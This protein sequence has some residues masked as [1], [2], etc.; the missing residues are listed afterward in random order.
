M[1]RTCRIS[2]LV[3]SLILV[4][5]QGAAKVAGAASPLAGKLIYLQGK[6]EVRRGQTEIWQA[7]QIDQDLLAGDAVKT[8]PLSR[9]AILCEDESQIKLN[10]HTL[11]VIESTAPSPRLQPAAMPATAPGAAPSLYGVPQGE[12]WLRNKNEKF[13]FELKT[14]SVSAAIRGTEF[15]LRVAADGT[16]SLTLLEGSLRL[17]NEYGALVLEPGEEGLARPGQAPTKR[18]L[19]QP[20]DAVQW[21]LFYPG[22][23]SYRDLPLASLEEGQAP[24]GSPV[25]AAL[26]RDSEAAYDRGELAQA[27]E[28]AEAA[29]KQDPENRR[30][31]T[32]LGW[33][34]LQRHAPEEAL[35][36]FRRVAAPEAAAGIGAALARYRLGDVTGAY[37]LLLGAHQKL[38]P[39]PLSRTMEGYFALL[40]GKVAEARALLET[41]S[42]QAPALVLPRALLAQIYLVQNRKDAARNEAAQAL[43][44]APGSPLAQLTMGLV[45]IAYFE[46]PSAR[47]HLEKALAADPGFIDAYVYLAKLWLGGDYLD[48]AWKTIEAALKLAPREGEVLA[49]AGFIRL[50]Y[51]DYRAAQEFFHQAIKASP[52]LGEPHLGLAIYQFRYRNYIRGVA[53]MLT[54]T[55][56]E[57]RVSQ[58]QSE[59]GKALYQVRA[60][61]KSLEVYDYAKTLDPKD[62][63][64]YL[65][66]G[67]ALTDLNRPGEAIQEIN[68]SIELN[69][70]RAVFRSR[71]GLDRDLAVRNSDLAR[72]YNQLAL[73]EW[74]QSKA[75]TAVKNDPTNSSAHLFLMHSYLNLAQS[76]NVGAAA[77]EELLYRLLAPANQAT[78]TESDDYTPMFEMPYVRAQVAGSIGAWDGGGSFQHPTANVYGGVPGAGF[79]VAGGYNTDQGFRPRNEDEKFYSIDNFV[80]W[81]PTVKDSLFAA[82][83]YAD[84]RSG[85]T[86]N[87]NDFAYKNDPYLRQF[88]HWRDYQLGYVHRFSPQWL[89]L[90][91]FNYHSMDNNSLK[92]LFSQNGIVNI[93]EIIRILTP[94][95]S[96]S[97]QIQNQLILGNHTLM[98]GFKYNEGH[99]I[100]RFHD[101]A[102]FSIPGI[103]IP[104]LIGNFIVDRRPPERVSSFYLL[105]YWRPTP[106][107]VLEGGLFREFTESPRSFQSEPISNA[108]WS[109]HFGINYQVNAQNTLRL[110]LMRH[111]TTDL[112]TPT[113]VPTDVASFVWRLD[114]LHGA[115]LRQAG[116]AWEAQWDAKTF[117]T[118][119]LAALRVDT[120]DLEDGSRQSWFGLRRYS[121]SFT[122]NRILTPAWG[123]TV[124]VS[125]KK[126]EEDFPVGDF[127]EVDALFR[128]W[129]QYPSGWMGGIRC[130][131]VQQDLSNLADKRANNLFGLFNVGFGKEF[132]RKRGFFFFSVENLFNRHFFYQL[133]P[134]TQD[135]NYPVRRFT[136]TVGL[137]F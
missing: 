130:S 98:A 137:N 124:G 135:S 47:Q 31:L 7:A 64:P 27:R 57:P 33:L 46:L 61:D 82:F 79:K 23:F 133:E 134:I 34:S 136:F 72:A 65:Y 6:V 1:T 66:K 107:L 13:R 71:L 59:L 123:L 41:A 45:E 127:S 110:A 54:A 39:T 36:Y 126:I 93:N 104:P 81:E 118:L 22:I 9:A 83:N 44:Q 75:V 114:T 43:S 38:K 80:K 69:D 95:Q 108:L 94:E 92:D 85:D 115:L 106:K 122:V 37:G 125:G 29:L 97:F 77:S 76:Q 24:P 19:V 32:I 50:G 131:L 53:E 91:F 84:V 17:A 70:N 109:G 73:N 4:L 60:F 58:Y 128:L 86:S 102:I 87:S 90:A 51:R 28:A 112:L 18:V 3:L 120:P 74:A 52:A 16:T 99:P 113:M 20:A 55:L 62:P 40:V 2:L 100:S 78:F 132:A 14:P 67:I 117:S 15:N 103:P 35:E 96:T 48:R 101:T 129:F 25:V 42:R 105:D 49:L 5:T 21:S 63:T 88:S 119:R 11:L 12:I 116:C 10:E 30:A 111:L 26:V 68:R 89:T 8:G 56:L 121:G